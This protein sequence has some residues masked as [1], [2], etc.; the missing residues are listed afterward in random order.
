MSDAVRPTSRLRRLFQAPQS[1]ADRLVPLVLAC[2]IV[3]VPCAMDQFS[4]SIAAPPEMAWR[5]GLSQHGMNIGMAAGLLLSGMPLVA[6]LLM[7]SRP[8]PW[9]AVALAAA[10]GLVLMLGSQHVMSVAV[11]AREAAVAEIDRATLEREGL[12]DGWTPVNV[13]QLMATWTLSDTWHVARTGKS[14]G[15][16]EMPPAIVRLARGQLAGV[17]WSLLGLL[18]PLAAALSVRRLRIPWWLALPLAAVPQAWSFLYWRFRSAALLDGAAWPEPSVLSHVADLSGTIVF[19]LVALALARIW[20]APREPGAVPA[21]P[22]RRAWAAGAAAILACCVGLMIELVILAPRCLAPPEE[23][24]S[25][26]AGANPGDAAPPIAVAA[27]ANVPLAGDAGAPAPFTS[28]KDGVTLVE[29]WGTWCGPCVRTLPEIEELHRTYEPLGL[30]VPG[31]TQE[32]REEVGTFLE[33]NGYS[34]PVG[35]DPEKVTV[36]AWA[37]RSWPT[38]FVLGRDGKVLLRASPAEAEDAVRRALGL[39][40]RVADIRAEAEAALAAGDEAKARAALVALVRRGDDA[41]I[42]WARARLAERWPVS[43]DEARA[44]AE[45]RAWVRL[46]GAAVERGAADGALASLQPFAQDEE[47]RA[48]AKE[49]ADLAHSEA[50]SALGAATFLLAGMH[51]RD[52]QGFF[53]VVILDGM[54]RSCQLQGFSLNTLTATIGGRECTRPMAVSLAATRLRAWAAWSDLADGHLPALATLDERAAE[55]RTAIL[56]ELDEKFGWH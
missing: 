20:G 42:G 41:Q 43:A 19:V 23:Q 46:V 18:L 54:R 25:A 37:V 50:V 53:E 4:H 5:V 34:F 52:S 24:R 36:K 47:L 12:A 51:P 48:L 39:A 22:P 16:A 9:R 11:R 21:V 45:R 30:R 15:G 29:F 17:P 44:L 31:I 55:R 6:V 33:R 32:T 3:L 2:A 49:R 14:R 13:D 26:A 10:G 28:M 1:R 8:R 40:L 38:T 27:W 7:A 35:F 56:A